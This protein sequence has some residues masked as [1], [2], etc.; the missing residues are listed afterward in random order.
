MPNFDKITVVSV[1]GKGDGYHA[2]LAIKKSMAELPGSKGLLIA[3]SKPSNLTSDI[4]FA[5]VEPFDYYQYSIFIMH[6]LYRFIHTEFALIVQDD[7]WVL[8]GKNWNDDWFNY[9]YIGAPCHAARVGNA[10]QMRYAWINNPSAIQLMNG[11][12]S[13]RSFKFLEAPTKYGIVYKLYKPEPSEPLVNEDVQLGLL[14]RSKLE[15]HGIV[16]CPIEKALHFSFEYLGPKIHD[17]ID[18]TKMLGHHAPVRKLRD[19]NVIE[20]QCFQNG[21]LNIYREPEIMDLFTAYGYKVLY[22]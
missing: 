8:N 9:D 5:P 7:G 20:Y 17:N 18:L 21:A 3:E 6:C 1:T 13:L 12:F 11:G 19:D 15:K 2:V 14:F 4:E 22:Q 16:F 10:I